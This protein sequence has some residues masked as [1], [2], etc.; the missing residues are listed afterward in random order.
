MRKSAFKASLAALIII[1]LVLPMFTIF[2]PTVFA[3]ENYAEENGWINTNPN[4]PTDYAYSIAI[5]GD[6][7]TLVKRHF[8]EGFDTMSTLY[9]WIAGN[10]ESKKIHY[11]LGMGDICENNLSTATHDE[12]WA[13]AKEHIT[14]LDGVVP[15]LLNRG[16]G[17]DVTSKFNAN[18]A[19][20]AYYAE[21]LSGTYAEGEIQ[22]A[23]TIFQ[24]GS[25]KYLAFALDYGANDDILAWA[26]GVIEANSDCKVIITTHAYLNSDGNRQTKGDGSVL[27]SNLN[28]ANNDGEDMWNEFVKKHENIFLV[29]CG[30]TMSNN[31]VYRQDVGDNGNVVTQMLVNPQGF[32]N[33]S[34]GDPK[35]MVCM[36]YFNEDGSVA[37]VEWISTVREQYYKESNQFR[38]NL[39]ELST[40]DGSIVTKYGTIPA[41]FTNADEYPFICFVDGEFYDTG[42]YDLFYYASGTMERVFRNI[43]ADKNVVVIARRDVDVIDGSTGYLATNYIDAPVTIDLMG[44]TV[45][46]NPA[47]PTNLFA[48]ANTQTRST[49]FILKNG[50]VILGKALLSVS[51]GGGEKTQNF[52]FEN[53]DIISYYKELM[54]FNKYTA[55]GDVNINFINCD[56]VANGTMVNA[57]KAGNSGDTNA[58]INAKTTVV[59]GSVTLSSFDQS[60][61][62]QEY[63]GSTVAFLPDDNGNM[64][65]VTVPS[66]TT[67][68]EKAY[69]GESG[70]LYLIEIANN[71][72]GDEYTLGSLVTEYG[73]IPYSLSSIV[74]YPF[75]AFVN[76]EVIGSAN[77][78]IDESGSLERTLRNKNTGAGATIILRRDFVLPK[79]GYLFTNQQKGTFTIDLMGHT[80]ENPFEEHLFTSA[81][82]NAIDNNTH[83]KNGTLILG[84][85]LWSVSTNANA[86]GKTQSITFENL[87]ITVAW[88]HITYH[89]ASKAAG[90][91][92][93]NYI[94]CKITMTGTVSSVFQAG[95]D[96]SDTNFV[97]NITVKG[98]KIRVPTFDQT[99][100]VTEYNG[101]SVNLIPG[102][103]GEYVTL[104]A[105]AIKNN[106][107]DKEY[108]TDNGER[109]L[110]KF[111]TSNGYGVY[112]L[113]V[114]DKLVN[115]QVSLTMHTSFIYNV[116]I[117][118]SAKSFITS[119]TLDGVNY[120]VNALPTKI[121]DEVEYLHIEK[122]IAA[123]EAGESYALVIESDAQK[124]SWSVGVISYTNLILNG[125][126]NTA[127]KALAKDILAYVRAIYAYENNENTPSVVE[128]VNALIGEDY[129]VN[130]TISAPV[131]STEGLS[132]AGLILGSRPAYYFIP[133]YDTDLYTFTINGAE[134]TTEV[135]FLNDKVVILVYTYAYAATET[136][137]Y[138]IE[139][140]GITGS[141]NLAAY[142]EFAS[143]TQDANLIGVVE[144]LW[145]YSDTAKAYKAQAND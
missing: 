55:A 102:D 127:E 29:L 83:V 21:N 7:Q 69:R 103:N 37:D 111:A 9:D 77:A 17:H 75:I 121:V 33:T 117:P 81:G 27:P 38:L 108:A 88:N 134:L 41:N 22:N 116:Y 5:V 71:T 45:N 115:P 12:E 23:Y 112:Y 16:A 130:P 19:S 35:G 24:A 84:K 132:G 101:G 131:M 46:A 93:I 129:A 42:A 109:T 124:Q 143:G 34:N 26:S 120:D 10:A 32:D 65:K 139:G 87:D 73:T 56:I 142:H 99:K 89:N 79:Q 92:N 14:K 50:T 136:V 85:G 66:G 52:T 76:N 137:S 90:N 70:D 62:V 145:Q 64:T 15:Y 36:L 2:A 28:A 105:K 8:D 1:G 119:I 6:T 138:T 133:E 60:N 20:H 4:A 31:L 114:A 58:L 100:F 144:A 118:L 126:Y 51:T 61:F 18:F 82:T 44:H 106:E 49:D 3:A 104:Y 97:T 39:Y 57:F 123:N 128:N 48:S 72:A 54:I 43:A 107:L 125:N 67:V 122:E 40:E 113:R 140:T 53:L 110:V 98:G 135:S 91:V 63:N 25:T 11:V 74:D 30:H 68:S 47:S 95:K 141:Y 94:D 13:Y 78:F 80:V 86:P 59:G 96:A